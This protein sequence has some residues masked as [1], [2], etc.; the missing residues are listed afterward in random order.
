MF[1]DIQTHN[2]STIYLNS[3]SKLQGT[4]RHNVQCPQISPSK[5]E[6]EMA[7]IS[8]MILCTDEIFLRPSLTWKQIHAKLSSRQI[9]GWHY[10]KITS[11]SEQQ[12]NRDNYCND[13]C[14]FGCL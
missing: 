7:S 11:Q 1:Q 13:F 12:Q 5:R 2:I 4:L 14:P 6:F 9:N 10:I 8:P 3:S